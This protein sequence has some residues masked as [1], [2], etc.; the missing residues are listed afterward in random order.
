MAPRAAH[1]EV[2]VTAGRYVMGTVLE[3]TIYAPDRASADA[4]LETAFAEASR[5]DA[6]MT[7]YDDAS[8]LMRLN[9]AAGEG[10]QRVPPE[11]A[12]LLAASVAYSRLTRGT[13]DVTVGPLVSLWRSRASRDGQVTD[14]ELAEVR[15][16]VGSDKI[17]LRDHATV[18]LARTGMALD[19]SGI[20]KGYA[21]DRIVA[22]LRRRGVARAYLSFGQSSI[23]ALGAPP[24]AHGWTV[25]LRDPA[26]GFAGSIE[27]RDRAMSVSSS[28]GGSGARRISHVIDP[29]SARPLDRDL[30][31]CVIASNATEAEALSKALLILGER[32]GV[33]LIERQPGA[34]GVLLDSHGRVSMTA[35]WAPATAFERTERASM[36]SN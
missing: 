1:G 17:V 10:A 21:L 32:D 29:R 36:S 5:L 23:W 4:L 34:G 24:G 8:A 14:S 33:A 15:A 20:A 25:A 2:A 31:A 19:L 18:E 12:E 26:G 3:A 30:E 22:M 13:F 7:T 9:R 28:F 27:L 16:L 6:M 35:G 11:L